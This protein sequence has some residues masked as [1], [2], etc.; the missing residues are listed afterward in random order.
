M[1]DELFRKLATTMGE[2][3]DDQISRLSIRESY[4]FVDLLEPQA[5]KL[6]NNLNGIEYNG[7]ELPI[8]RASVISKRPPRGGDRRKS[9]D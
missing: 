5:S 7:T 4:G 8:E 9:Q 3:N 2:I 6:I 1:T